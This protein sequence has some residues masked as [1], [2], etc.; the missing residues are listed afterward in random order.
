MND[1]SKFAGSIP[2]IYD[3]YL[4]PLIFEGFAR[5]LAR[6]IA[7]EKPTHVLETAAGSGVVT[8]KLAPLLSSDASYLVTD[9]NPPMIER[10][11]ARQ[12]PDKRLSWRPADAL[13]IPCEDN[14][15]DALLCQF[16]VMFFPDRTAGFAEA[17]RAL[18]PGGLFAFNVW[19]RLD[20]NVFP[21]IVVDAA[22]ALFPD[23]P[24]RFLERTPHGYHDIDKISADMRD[25][26]FDHFEIDTLTLKSEAKSPHVPAFAF[27]QGT[28][29]RNELE[30]L[31]ADLDHVTSVT[32]KALSSRFG[33]GEVT[34]TI[35]AHIVTA[36]A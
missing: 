14:S 7:A 24:P 36:R 33:T 4:V 29:M 11:K 19:D 16:G 17:R 15:F 20:T 27:C 6:R 1:D 8:R 26:G 34:S 35:Q 32:E 22:A 25:A 28:P 3:D 21:H 2:E 10:A 23:N 31:K 12:D 18:R 30:A 5:D 9:L 13:N